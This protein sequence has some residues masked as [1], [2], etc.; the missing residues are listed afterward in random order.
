MES[1]L[2]LEGTIADDG[3]TST[4]LSKRKGPLYGLEAHRTSDVTNWRDS[5][6]RKYT[7]P[8]LLVHFPY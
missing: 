2:L 6:L 3:C 7:G 1:S 4:N 5:E 8:N